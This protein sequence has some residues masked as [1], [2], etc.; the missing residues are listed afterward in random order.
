MYVLCVCNVPL[1]YRISTRAVGVALC[2]AQKRAAT[3][4][5]QVFLFLMHDG[6]RFILGRRLTCLDQAVAR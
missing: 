1:K 6:K 4:K 3:R 2:R 5:R